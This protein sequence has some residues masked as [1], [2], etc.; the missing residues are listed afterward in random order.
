MPSSSRPAQRLWS[1]GG[2]ECLLI[3]RDE[4]PRFEVCVMRGEDVLKQDW[5]YA[6]ASA[7]M[8]AE[9]WQS[10]LSRQSNGP[11]SSTNPQSAILNPQ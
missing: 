3:E 8:L 2:T 5:L 10:T 6:K 11:Q 1:S 7:E 9:T 4:A